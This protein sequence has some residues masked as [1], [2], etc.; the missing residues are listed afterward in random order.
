MPP[1]RVPERTPRVLHALRRERARGTRVEAAVPVRRESASGRYA[2]RARRDGRPGRGDGRR[3]HRAELRWRTSGSALARGVGRVRP[4][5]QPRR[6]SPPAV[7]LVVGKSFKAADPLLTARLGGARTSRSRRA[8][9]ATRT[10]FCWRC[11][12]AADLPRAIDSWFVR[13]SPGS[14]SRSFATTSRSTWIHG[15]PPRRPVRQLPHRRRRTGR[16]PR[17]RFWGH[18][19]PGLGLPRSGTPPAS[20]ASRSSSG[21]SHRSFPDRFDP[22]RVA[23]DPIRMPCSVCRAEAKREPCTIDGWWHDSGAAPFANAHYPFEPGPFDPAAPARLRRRG[24]RPDARMVLFDARPLD[25]ASSTARHAAVAI[26]NGLVLD[27]SRPEDEQVQGERRGTARPFGK[28]GGDVVRWAFFT[29]DYTEPTKLHGGATSGRAPRGSSGTLV[30][31]ALV[32]PPERGRRRASLP[33]RVGAE[34]RAGLL[35]QWLLSRASTRQSGRRPRALDDVRP[36]GRAGTIGTFVDDVSTWYLRRSRPRFWS[37][38]D[39][40]DAAG[41]PM[42]RSP[43]ALGDARTAS[44]PRSLRSR[45]NTSR[46]ELPRVRL[47]GGGRSRSTSPAGRARRVTTT[48]RS[49]PRW[50]RFGPRWRSGGSFANG[51]S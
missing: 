38:T 9:S 43:Y 18:A 23:V 3:P 7:P 40:A 31:V 12:N 29:A 22:H 47:L 34:P 32:L 44:S 37:E 15:A 51:R 10:P 50:Q 17:K 14:T 4:A 5:R 45:P 36:A 13:T 30:N 27:D 48:D 39:V 26:A 49:M 20:G 21:W 19:A 1:S 35:G 8:R 6:S 25:R 42:T 33:A 46:Q 2:G 28:H 41:R 16:S 24:A 11:G